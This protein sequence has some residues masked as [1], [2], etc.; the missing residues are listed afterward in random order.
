MLPAL[1]LLRRLLMILVHVATVLVRRYEYAQGVL[2]VHARYTMDCAHYFSVEMPFFLFFL[3][4]LLLFIHSTTTSFSFLL[5]LR[6]PLFFSYYFSPPPS[7]SRFTSLLPISSFSQSPALARSCVPVSS[8]PH[9]IFA[10]RR[11]PRDWPMYGARN[12]DPHLRWVSIFKGSHLFSSF[13]VLFL[14][15]LHHPASLACPPPASLIPSTPLLLPPSRAHIQAPSSPTGW[16]TNWLSIVLPSSFSFSFP[17]SSA[18]PSFSSSSSSPTSSSSS[19]PP[20]SSFPLS[21]SGDSFLRAYSHRLSLSLFLYICLA[22][23]R[24]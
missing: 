20:S 1:L 14:R 10:P 8:S 4:L 2:T 21:R 11:P 7:S 6:L 9:L 17:S 16:S 3:H 22:S 13:C 15:F 23:P 12:S 19:S 18:S 24:P 5:P